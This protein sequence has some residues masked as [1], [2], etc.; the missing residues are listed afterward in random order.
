MSSSSDDEQDS[1]SNKFRPK[2]AQ[3]E[4]KSA[5]HDSDS[6]NLPDIVPSSS[7]DGEGSTRNKSWQKS[8]QQESDSADLPDL[9][10][11]SAED[12]EDG[13]EFIKMY[14]KLLNGKR[15]LLQMAGSDTI[16][17]LNPPNI[18][19]LSIVDIL[20]STTFVIQ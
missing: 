6:E 20:D 9:E 12:N 19:Y 4:S 10:L 5:Q 3:H 7:E 1:T 15:F 11:S 13:K 18:K 8:E 17:Y 14:V 2:S 16:L